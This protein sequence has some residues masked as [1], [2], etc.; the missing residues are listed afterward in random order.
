MANNFC[1]GLLES[2]GFCHFV[3]FSYEGFEE[4]LMALLCI[5]SNVGFVCLYMDNFQWEE[6]IKVFKSSI[7]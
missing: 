6:E 1:L 3:G 7:I 4:E 5:K 2:E